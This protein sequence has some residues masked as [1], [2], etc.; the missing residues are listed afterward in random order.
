M[1]KPLTASLRVAH[2]AGC[3]SGSRTSVDSLEGCTCK[4]G[5]TYYTFHRDRT[6][7]TTKGPRVRD[8]QVA[9][10]ALRKLLVELDEER[11]DVG[12]RRREVRTFGAWAEEHL[13]NLKYD[14]GI[15]SS[16]IRGYRSTLAYAIP[17]FGSLKLDE[18]RQPEVRLFVRAI[19]KRD[20]TDATVKKHLK[21]LNAIF[22]AAVDEELMLRNPIGRKFVRDLRLRVPRGVEPYTNGELAKLWAKME[23]LDRR[24]PVYLYI[25]KAAVT[26][27][28]RLGE[29]IALNWDDLNLT[30]KRLRI[31][32]HWDPVDGATLPKDN[33]ARTVFLIPD[34]VAVF[35]RWTALAGIQPGDSPIFPAPRGRDRLNGQFVSRRVNDARERAG[36]A[37]VGEGGR[38]RKPFHAFRATFDRICLEQGRDRDWVRQQLGHSSL[39]LTI[40][41]YGA[42]SEDAMRAE[43]DRAEGFPV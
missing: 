30:G 16:T 11:V 14:R 26:T 15:K 36:I 10:R 31:R 5:P 34:A 2:R 41:T 22:N 8:R 7:K 42:W 6:G 33:E 32:R 17:I 9:E 4:P 38:K 23:A 19:R 3:P 43:A 37:D 13:G 28:A 25:A 35:E 18:I 12:P 1:S 27:G 29:L 40:D 21:H 24:S 39:A 20:C